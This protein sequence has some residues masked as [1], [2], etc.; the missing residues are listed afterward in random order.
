MRLA[1]FGR[2][3]SDCWNAAVARAAFISSG[4]SGFSQREQ[5]L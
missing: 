4:I 2:H 5:K 3:L 1:N